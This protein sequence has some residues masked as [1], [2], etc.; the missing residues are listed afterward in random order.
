MPGLHF[1]SQLIESKD[2]RTN[3]QI[4]LTVTPNRGNV[5]V[6]FNKTLTLN[7]SISQPTYGLLPE[8]LIWQ[9][10][11][12]WKP[13]VTYVLNNR[14]VQLRMNY[15]R[16]DDAG[17]YRCVVFYNVSKFIHSHEIR[18]LVGVKCSSPVGLSATFEEDRMKVSWRPS[19][20]VW[21]NYHNDVLYFIFYNG[22]DILTGN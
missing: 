8:Q 11:N 13:N 18:V 9:H 1:N 14:T 12:S 16:D 20:L 19:P 6:E 10:N 3:S 17:L 5:Y 21:P 15:V 4:T 7:C 2:Q 22:T